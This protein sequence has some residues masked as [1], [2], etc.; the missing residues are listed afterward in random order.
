MATLLKNIFETLKKSD[1]VLFAW[2]VLGRKVPPPHVYKRKELLKIA[3]KN[4][5]KIL[6]ETG[7]YLGDMVQGAKK[8]FDKIYSIEISEYFYKNAKERFKNDRNVELIL[9][10]ST[11]KLKETLKKVKQPAL[12]WLDG[13]YSGGKTSRGKL[14][15]PIIQELNTV[16]SQQ[17]KNHVI[18][19]DDARCFNGH[20]D[21]P[22]INQLRKLIRVKAPHYK[23][24]VEN[25]IIRVTPAQK[26]FN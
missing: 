11:H 20:D 18:L 3:K 6:I 5:I 21:Y 23:L 16:F 8:K 2:I 22:K 19:I 15:T 12:L 14:N 24:A 9:G 7:T 1:L 13:H 26:D 17:I 10:D 4:N 25:D